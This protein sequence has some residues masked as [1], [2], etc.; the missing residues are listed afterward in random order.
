MAILHRVV[1]CGLFELAVGRHVRR[2]DMY[3]HAAIMGDMEQ[4]AR[5]HVM[6]ARSQK[7]KGSYGQQRTEG[8]SNQVEPLVMPDSGDESGTKAARGIQAGA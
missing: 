7:A 3:E 4:L 1:L 2:L 5:Q 6:P 8:W